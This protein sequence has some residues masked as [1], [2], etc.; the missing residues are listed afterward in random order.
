MKKFSKRLIY[1]RIFVG[2]F[3]GI[4]ASIYVLSSLLSENEEAI[5]PIAIFISLGTGFVVFVFYIIYGILFYHLSGYEI[6]ENQIVCKRGVI[7]K[8]KSILDFSK[9]N[10]VNKKQSIFQ[11]M[12]GISSL[13]ID[14][15]STNSAKEEEV[16][17]IEDTNVVNELYT[18]FKSIDKNNPVLSLNKEKNF[19][20]NISLE[21]DFLEN[22]FLEK[23][24]LDVKVEE[25]LYTFDSQS[26]IIYTFVNSFLYLFLTICTVFVICGSLYLNYLFPDENSEAI[27]LGEILVVTISTFVVFLAICFLGSLL[28]AFIGYY[29]YKITKINDTINVEYGLLVNNHNSF[30]LSKVKGVVITQGL[31]QRLFKLAT[32]KVEVIGYVEGNNNQA[33]I[34]MLIPLCKKKEISTY[35]EKIIPS[36]IPLKQENKAKAFIPFISWYTIIGGLT[37]ILLMIPASLISLAY[38]SIEAL[39]ALDSIILGIYLLGLVICLFDGL[40]AYHAQD[41][42]IDSENITIYT[43]SIT[44]AST[45]IKKNNIIA[46]ED[47]TTPFRAKCGIYSYVIHFH[48]NAFS[49]TKTVRILDEEYRDELLDCMKY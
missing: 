40:F 20:E 6:K 5:N 46:I 27:T 42:R 44:K 23:D 47:I 3:L 35:L 25:N 18:L 15:G 29:N 9:I 16:L 4:F 24:S 8:K 13:K 19:L 30:D 49:N 7:F 26:K 48:T 45:V 22:N 37:S 38:N 11:K 2:F 14:S 39:I 36:H 34:G 21:K 10:S 31:F 12:F 32:I 41:I 43:G 1:H 28:R 17:V 33:S